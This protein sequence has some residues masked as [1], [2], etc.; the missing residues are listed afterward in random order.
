MAA[1]GGEEDGLVEVVRH[2]SV[3]GTAEMDGIL[4][5]EC[6]HGC[7]LN[8]R[9]MGGLSVARFPNGWPPS[10]RD[11][12][13]QDLAL[14]CIAASREVDVMGPVYVTENFRRWMSK[15]VL[16]ERDLC[17]AVAEMARGLIRRRFG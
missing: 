6:S 14:T 1:G 10:G 17:R 4:S 15:Q 13:G 8:D 11:F 2:R 9:K 3:P 7:H 12:I 16:D 5:K